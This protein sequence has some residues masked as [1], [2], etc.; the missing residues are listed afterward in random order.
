MRKYT[1]DEIDGTRNY[2][3]RQGFQEVQASI[4]NLN[5]SYF[6]LPQ[7]LEP[8]IRDFVFRCTGDSSDNYVFGISDS[9]GEEHRPYAVIHE[10]I[11]FI[12]IGIETPNRCVSA[13]DE[14]LSLVP[15]S[16]KPEHIRMR[17]DFF[18]NLIPYVSSQPEN[19]TP[20]DINEFKQSLARLEEIVN[21][22]Q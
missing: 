12:K 17:R 11:E 16:I 14:E 13:L 6:V 22:S 7:T 8:R 1:K 4:G 18:K 9:V 3:K 10:F 20:K 15:E 5:F 2:F 21:S 19:Y